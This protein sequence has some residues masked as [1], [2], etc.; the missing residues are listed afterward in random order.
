L[1]IESRYK[2]CEK[3]FF[4]L[5]VFT[6]E[7]R[8]DIMKLK[9]FPGRGGNHEKKTGFDHCLYALLH[10]AYGLVWGQREKEWSNRDANHC[11]GRSC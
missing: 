6:K 4:S 11:P 5:E 7:K 1:S 9:D 2:K 10:V 8:C 3:L